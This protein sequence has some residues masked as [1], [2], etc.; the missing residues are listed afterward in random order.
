MCA[1]PA[2]AAPYPTQTDSK[3][4]RVTFWFCPVAAPNVHC[5]HFFRMI[6]VGESQYDEGDE[7]VSADDLRASGGRKEGSASRTSMSGFDGL[8]EGAEASEYNSKAVSAKK[9]ASTSSE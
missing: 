6:E 7:G 3:P 8:L 5:A 4:L 1:L 2:Y 9:K